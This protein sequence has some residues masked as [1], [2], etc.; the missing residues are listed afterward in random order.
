MDK[1]AV[2]ISGKDNVATA[3]VEL[4]KGS[5][6]HMYV[7][8]KE[9]SVKVVDDI[10]FGHKFAIGNIKKNQHIIKYGES[11]GVITEDTI[12]GQHVHVHN[13]DSLRGRGDLKGSQRLRKEVKK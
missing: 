11:I 4:T 10:P 8:G 2:V 9:I 7:G 6:A 1:Q 3:V 12:A 13:V 5:T